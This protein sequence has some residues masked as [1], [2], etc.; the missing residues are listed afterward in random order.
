[1]TFAFRLPHDSPAGPI[2]PISGGK[3]YLA[4]T[5]IK[6]LDRTV[7]VAGGGLWVIPNCIRKFLGESITDGFKNRLLHIVSLSGFHSQFRP[8]AGADMPGGQG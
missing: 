1:M 8:H 2:A 7:N 5:P 4:S 3:K 6:V